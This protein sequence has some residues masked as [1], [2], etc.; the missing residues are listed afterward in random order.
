M[1]HN[2]PLINKDAPLIG[3]NFMFPFGSIV[4]VVKKVQNA[5]SKKMMYQCMFYHPLTNTS[6]ELAFDVD[7]GEHEEFDEANAFCRFNVKLDISS[8]A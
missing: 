4:R 7:S 1:S 3:Y 8:L 2:T 5:K 6:H